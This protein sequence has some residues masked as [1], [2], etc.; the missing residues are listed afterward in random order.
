MN[1]LSIFRAIS[2]RRFEECKSFAPAHTLHTLLLAMLV[3][4]ALSAQAQVITPLQQ[5]ALN[6][7]VDYANQSADEMTAVVKSII[8]YYP[9]LKQKRS[10]GPPRY[11]CPVQL[12][13]YYAKTALALQKNI[14][15][16]S[17][18]KIQPAMRALQD[19]AAK[20][21]E[22][23]KALDTYHKLEDYKQD[24][25]AK[26]LTIIENIPP[27]LKSYKEKQRALN[28]ALEDAYKKLNA[29]APQGV[30]AKSDAAIRRQVQAERNLIDQWT[31]NIAREVHTGWPVEK[32]EA[33]IMQTDQALVS[34][35]SSTPALKYP[36]SSMWTSFQGSLSDIL[37]EKRRG[38]DQYTYEAKKSDEY[39]NRVYM[40]LINYFNGGVLTNYN[41]F[42]QF[43]EGNGYHGLKAIKYFPLYEIRTQSQVENISVKPFEDIPHHA[44]SFPPA[45][46]AITTNAFIVLTEYIE[47][48]NETWRQVNHLQLIVGNFSSSAAYYKNIDDYSRHGA[49]QFDFKGLEIPLSSYQKVVVDSKVLPPLASKT[50]N[51]QATVILNILKEM[52]EQCASLAVDVKE[53]KYEQ[54]RLG[55]TYKVLE[56]MA[57]LFST[58]DERKEVL[59]IDLRA[60][61]DSH[62]V[63]AP[64]DN[65][66][67]SGKALL[68]LTDL[69]REQLFKAKAY[70][71]G[72]ANVVISTEKIDATLRDVIAN[73]YTNMK[74]IEKIGRN[75]GNCPYTPYE[76]LPKNSKTLSEHL[77]KLKPAK[78]GFYDHPYHSMVYMYN[79]IA[80]D[81]NKFCDLSKTIPHLKV[82]KQPELFQLASPKE[83]MGEQKKP[84]AQP[85]ISVKAAE[86]PASVT[87]QSNR[88]SG[89]PPPA[90]QSIKVVH[91]TV[92]IERRDT[93][94]IYAGDEN[95]RSME[96]YATNNLVLLLDVS[97]SMNTPEKFPVLKKSVLDLISMM[98]AEDQVSIITFSSK[99]KVML[100]AISF[101]EEEK[102]KKAIESL[103]SSGKTDGDAG[104][105]L[106]YKVADEHYVRGGNNRIILATDG[107]FVL[108]DATLSLIQKFSTQDIYLSI[109]NFGKGMGSSKNLEKL[110]HLGKGNY[111]YIAK[112]N[113]D[114]KLIREVKAKRK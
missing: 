99:P 45:K 106:A 60:Y 65:W 19:A 71:L 87:A 107:E 38:L 1:N 10:W 92:Y 9:S 30:Y 84:A 113:V 93:V 68:N 44:V 88:G 37:E 8:D 73:E 11:T 82:V 104:I 109:F 70:Y 33:S 72:N 112:E 4:L 36:A 22:Q 61:F 67:I 54:D 18:A 42:L 49:M 105:S 6:A 64:T 47:F 52:N 80:D 48:L 29:G 26:A 78:E 86:A 53:R 25:F 100:D 69:D 50:F 75:N 90:S 102:I 85:N 32:L 95:L 3:F 57:K 58:W 12:E 91:D 103:K 81:Y 108:N 15:A 28:T 63:A 110:A 40:D 74:G 35:K 77:Q 14:P 98:R 43:S 97:G 83:K 46:T 23:C 41:T 39:S 31:F 94:T 34:L 55:N 24:N 20:I 114:V 17:L 27:L 13:E 21:D 66:Y 59:Y 111:E 5:K 96:G 7:H 76:D 51:D 101:K 89:T 2:Q 56:R 79:E 62:P 16:T